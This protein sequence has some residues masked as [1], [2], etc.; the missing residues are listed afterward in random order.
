MRLVTVILLLL[1]ASRAAGADPTALIQRTNGQVRI[2]WGETNAGFTVESSTNIRSPAVWRMVPLAPTAVGTNHALV[3]TPDTNTFSYYRLRFPAY[4]NPARGGLAYLLASQNTDGTW[5][6]NAVSVNETT[7]LV[8]DLLARSSRGTSTLYGGVTTLR[9]LPVRNYDEL[10][11]KIMAL[12]R[13]N[14]V[15]AGDRDELIE[16]QS[17]EIDDDQHPSYPGLGWGLARGYGMNLMDSA[18]AFQALRTAGM[19]SGLSFYNLTLGPG[20]TSRWFSVEIPEGAD[21]IMWWIRSS[22]QP[23]YVQIWPPGEDPYEFFMNSALDH[24]PLGVPPGSPGV[25][26]FAVRNAAG[27]SLHVFMDLGFTLDDGFDVLRLSGNT[28]Y[29]RK[30]Q[31]AN[32]GWG[33]LGGWQSQLLPT[34][35]V[36][37]ALALLGET[38]TQALGSATTWI[39]TIQNPDGGFSVVPSNSSVYE[40]SIAMAAIRLYDPLDNLVSATT[41][42]TN[43]QQATGGWSNSPFL[44]AMAVEALSRPPVIS[45]I[46]DQDVLRPATFSA[47]NLDNFVV[48]PNHSDTQLVWAASCP[49]PSS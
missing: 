32:G 37:K 42:L 16:G 28:H 35:E 14:G 2:Y 44:T 39:R 10:S 4:A 9:G 49:S 13:F 5:D 30:R 18:L 47:I 6:T 48:D 3:F 7:A 46:P 8:Y 22:D 21:S 1:G 40:T 38:H 34:Y 20:A 43:R 45:S 15:I 11:R 27:S 31:N 41:Y 19:P 29:L 26:Q 12:V 24:Y 25:W 33:Y 17:D 36:M 23:M